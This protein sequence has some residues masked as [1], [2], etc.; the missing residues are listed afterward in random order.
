[1]HLILSHRVSRVNLVS[2]VL[3]RRGQGGAGVIVLVV[4]AAA[5]LW[6]FKKMDFRHFLLFGELAQC[7]GTSSDFV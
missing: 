1:M 4:V 5:L 3:H 6:D 7:Y 2:V